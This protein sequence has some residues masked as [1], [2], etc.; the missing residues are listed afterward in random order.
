M[1]KGILIG[2]GILFVAFSAGGAAFFALKPPV[3]QSCPGGM[4][5]AKI[6][7]AFDLIDQSGQRF[8][9]V[10]LE[11]EVNLLYFGFATCP[12][13]CPTDLADMAAA[14]DILEEG[15]HSVR[16]VFITVDPER[17]T[18]ELMAEHVAYFHPRMIGLT[19]PLEATDQ[20]AKAYRV[21]YRKSYDE[22]FPDGYLMDH[23]SFKYLVGSDGQFL[24][25]FG[26]D[27]TPEKIAEVSACHIAK[28]SG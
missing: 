7:G 11:G 19:G 6:G 21:Y 3:E 8:T 25:F 12:D 26:R 2:I 24:T 16:P 20:A 23:S 1:G 17:D 15:G 10:Q 27:D 13:I 28:A 18:P 22:E 5:G 4:A 9:E 14:T